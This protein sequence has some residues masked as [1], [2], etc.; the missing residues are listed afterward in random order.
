MIA[1]KANASDAYSEQRAK[2][3][4]RIKL[5]NIC[6][7]TDCKGDECK[8]TN[9]STDINPV[10]IDLSHFLCESIKSNHRNGRTL[11][12]GGF[13]VVR[14]VMKLTSDDRGTEYA[15]K[16]MSKA[17]ILKRSS[18]PASVMTELRAL[19][20]LLDCEYVCSIKYAFQDAAHLYIV[21]ELARGGDMRYNMRL[22][23]YSKFTESATKFYACQIFLA[24]SYCHK[25]SILHRG[26]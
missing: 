16:S 5:S 22:S 18:G 10:E 8:G 25:V 4:K 26:M 13:G 24:V 17:A 2:N 1:F 23:P 12:L 15:M 6:L 11:G 21:L 14:R 19:V 9:I 7:S 20:M 3:S